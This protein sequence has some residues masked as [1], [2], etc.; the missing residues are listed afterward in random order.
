MPVV[1][2]VPQATVSNSFII[3]GA[4][5]AHEAIDED[6]DTP[7]AGDRIHSPAGAGAD[8]VIGITPAPSDFFGINLIQYQYTIQWEALSDDTIQFAFSLWDA[9]STTQIASERI[10]ASSANGTITE[11]Q[12]ESVLSSDPALWT[13]QP[14][15]HL[16][17]EYTQN[18]GGDGGIGSVI[19][20]RV[21]LDYSTAQFDVDDVR[22]AGV[23]SKVAP[24]V[25]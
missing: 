18:M 4:A 12:T 10:R 20:I 14:E 11:T 22:V 5:T 16:G 19:A 21:I 13:T 8:A 9:G 7:D 25:F 2:L 15:F 3:V 6:P 17:V 24:V 1:E 23:H